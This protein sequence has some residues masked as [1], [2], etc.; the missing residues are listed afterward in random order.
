MSIYQKILKNKRGQSSFISKERIRELQSFQ[1]KLGIR[2]RDIFLLNHALVHGSFANEMKN[3]PNNE[4]LEFLGDSVLGLAISAYLYQKWPE[5]NEGQM[6][7]MRSYVVSEQSLSNLALQLGVDQVILVSRGEENSGGRKKRAILADA[8]EAII[9]AYFLDAGFPRSQQAIVRWLEPVVQTVRENRHKKDYKSL[10][11]QRVQQTLHAN[12]TYHL[13][14]RSGPAHKQEF[15]IE[16]V[17]N[18]QRYGPG[19]GYSKKAAEQQAAA[20]AYKAFF[21][22]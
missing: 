13:L 16:V 2:F 14:K 21:K 1:K 19:R 9:A 8:M 6:T 11:Q 12:P 18:D 5:F 20:L 17:I 22:Q 7:M 15:F 3:I 10:L 4:K